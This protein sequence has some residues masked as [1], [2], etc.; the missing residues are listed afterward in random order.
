LGEKGKTSDFG[1]DVAIELL[2]FC[3]VKSSEEAD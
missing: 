3:F 2:A 1:L